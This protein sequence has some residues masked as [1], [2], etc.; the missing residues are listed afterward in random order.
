VV[1]SGEGKD[2]L[3][4]KWHHRRDQSLVLPLQDSGTYGAGP[5]LRGEAVPNAVAE[6]VKQRDEAVP[7]RGVVQALLERLPSHQVEEGGYGVR[8][9]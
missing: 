2:T 6:R 3:P 7:G 1:L 9:G 5:P 8:G 4:L